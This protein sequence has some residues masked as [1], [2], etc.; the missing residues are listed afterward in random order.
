M[1]HNVIRTPAELAL[2]DRY[3][4]ERASLPGSAVVATLRDAAFGAVESAGLPHRRVEAWKYTDLRANLKAIA[5][6]AGPADPAAIAAAR[7]AVE[8]DGA[9]RLIVA[10]G[11]FMAD[12]S[13]LADLEPGLAI[14]ALADALDA[15][16]NTVLGAFAESEAAN[17]N[18]AVDLNTAFMTDGLVIDVEGGAT[19][20]RPIEIVH[21]VDAE[22]PL[23]TAVRHLVQVGS[24]A[25]VTVIETVQSL[26]PIA[27]QSNIVTFLEVGDGAK[28]DHIRLQLEPET[29]VTLTTV[30]ARI[31]EKARFDSF[32]AA[33][34]GGIARAQLFARFAGCDAVG[35]FR[36]VTLLSGRRHAD[37]TLEVIHDAAHCQSRELYKAVVDDG[38]RSAFAGRISVPSHAQKTDARMMTASLLL[39]EDAEADAKPELEIFADDV[40]CGHGATCGAIDED[41]LFYLQ[42]R[43]IPK[44]EAES[45]LILAFLGE[46]ID[47]IANAAV[48]DA[49][50][51]RVEAWLKARAS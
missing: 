20:D 27:N 9:R 45:M 1:A 36:G 25:V 37:T 46:A 6:G 41:L 38:A 35:G 47:E 50:I 48:H 2:F 16:D 30:V 10:N 40:Q 8:G 18:I 34:G 21:L 14:T 33:L 19:I 15:G 44:A 17:A 12:L 28:V 32:N 24:G 51:Q 23:A 49:L 39:S 3:P 42:A 13:D 26:Q 11:R 29:A 5:P 31:G 22:T 7:P 4:A 43:G